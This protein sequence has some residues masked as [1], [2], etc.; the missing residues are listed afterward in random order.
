MIYVTTAGYGHK[1]TIATEMLASQPSAPV[2]PWLLHSLG[3]PSCCS[4]GQWL[5]LTAGLHYMSGMQQLLFYMYTQHN[6]SERCSQH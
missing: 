5:A 2:L 3:S 6:L 4:A 1:G